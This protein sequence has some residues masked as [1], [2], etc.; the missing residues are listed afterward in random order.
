VRQRI[1]RCRELRPRE[2]DRPSN[3][4]YMMAQMMKGSSIHARV[5]CDLESKNTQ[6]LMDGERRTSDQPKFKNPGEHSAIQPPHPQFLPLRPASWL[7][8]YGVALVIFEFGCR[9]WRPMQREALEHLAS[10]SVAAKPPPTTSQQCP[11]GFP[12]VQEWAGP[13]SS[14]FHRVLSVQ[15]HVRLSRGGRVAV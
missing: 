3:I 14:D 12:P 9:R 1:R 2:I 13:E 7:L 10:N 5:R 11:F 4:E 8:G 6:P 15:V